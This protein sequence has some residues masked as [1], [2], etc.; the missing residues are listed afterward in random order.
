[1]KASKKLIGAS[2]ALVAALAVSVGTTFAWFTTN[3]KVTV[4]NIEASVTTGDSNLEV[5][6]IKKDG[7]VGTFGYTLNLNTTDTLKEMFDNTKFDALTDNGAY[8]KG[9]GSTAPSFANDKSKNGLEL[10][11]KKGKEAKLYG[12]KDVA[13]G[14]YIAFNLRFR[15]PISEDTK[16]GLEL[17]LS[18]D[19]SVTSKHANEID[20]ASDAQKAKYAPLV[21]TTDALVT[22]FGIDKDQPIVTKAQDAIRIAFHELDNTKVNTVKDDTGAEGKVW[23]PNQSEYD[24]KTNNL[25]QHVE[26]MFT[27]GK[28][29]AWFANL[30]KAPK[31]SPFTFTNSAS[32]SDLKASTSVV[33]MVDDTVSKVYCTADVRVIIW[34]EG[35]DADCLNSIFSDLVTIKLGFELVTAE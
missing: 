30:Y 35:T 6:L 25:A 13:V 26:A 2:V 17:K 11:D 14:N 32:A 20:G 1:M 21:A 24:K 28:D 27:E 7:T 18:Y 15:T 16:E 9:D 5:A 4:E 3:N 23:T 22:D 19:S 10:L 12:E 33:K 8:D 34:L 31:Y 29:V